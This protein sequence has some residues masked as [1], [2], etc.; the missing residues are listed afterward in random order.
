MCSPL[1]CAHA[2]Q[3]LSHERSYTRGRTVSLFQLI[4]RGMMMLVRVIAHAT[5]YDQLAASA[6]RTVQG[7]GSYQQ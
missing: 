7:I 3:D 5:E 4:H 2:R 6:M 1:G